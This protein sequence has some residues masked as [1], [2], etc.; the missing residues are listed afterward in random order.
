MFR[1]LKRVAATGAVIAVVGG[2]G[3]TSL[4]FALAEEVAR[5]GG[6]GIVTTT[7]KMTRPHWAKVD[8]ECKTANETIRSDLSA[9]RDGAVT[10]VHAGLDTQGRYLGLSGDAITALA[11]FGMALLTVE[12]DGS[13]GRPFKAPAEHEPV[14]PA[15]ASDVVVSVGLKVLGQPLNSANVHRPERVAAVGMVSEG[16]PVTSS[17]ITRVLLSPEAGHKGVPVKARRHALLNAPSSDEHLRI[18]QHIAQK[19]VYGGFDSAVVATAHEHLVH[20]IVR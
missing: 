16:D 2:G 1:S 7:T 20:A 15:C 11:S 9:P 19:L 3:K 12:A 13:A 4:A 10:L 17:L 6:A 8:L 14:I 5:A 18:G